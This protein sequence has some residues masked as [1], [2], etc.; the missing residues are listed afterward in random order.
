MQTFTGPA[1]G[2]LENVFWGFFIFAAAGGFSGHFTAIERV[3]WLVADLVVVALVLFRPAVYFALIWRAFPVVIWP[4][5]AILSFLW[6]FNQT[7]SIYYGLQLLL[8]ILMGFALID[9]LGIKGLAHVVYYALGISI[10]LS[11]IFIALSVPGSLGTDGAWIGIYTH[12]NVLGRTLVLMIITAFFFIMNKQRPVLNI[13][14]CI[15]CII[16]LIQ[17]K[18]MTSVTVFAAI[19]VFLLIA[20]SL[21]SRIMSLLTPALLISVAAA[22]GLA[23]V[24]TNFGLLDAYLESTDKDLTFTGR[25]VL[26]NFAMDAF[27]RRPVLGYGYKGYWESAVTTRDYLRFYIDQDLWF[28]HNNFFEVAV[29]F[30][31]V[32]LVIFVWTLSIVYFRSIYSIINNP[33]A[34]NV[35]ANCVLIQIGILTLSENPLFEN[36]GLF[37][38]LFAACYLHF[39]LQARSSRATGPLE[40]ARQ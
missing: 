1:P 15:V 8:T 17:S 32:G 12:K 23:I 7:A 10:V 24:L 25:T 29:A 6:S 40:P 14:I 9:R 31:I 20:L 33:G 19:L 16:A 27:E 37:Q 21:N 5:I 3:S 11:L 34:I 18:S 38:V 39:A 2:R 26:W 30:G 35:W 13:F 22:F 28:F 36:H 4:F